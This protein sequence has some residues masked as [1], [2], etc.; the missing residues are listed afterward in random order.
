MASLFCIAE[1]YDYLLSQLEENGGELTEE[2]EEQ[3]A[4]TEEELEDKLRSYKRIIDAQKSNVIYNKDEI[5]RLRERNNS[6]ENANNKLNQAIVS[7]LYKFG[8]RGKSGNYNLKYPDFTV[9]TKASESIEI[10]EHSLDNIVAYL[11]Y[12]INHVLSSEE[13]H[14]VN[15]C[16]KYLDRVA[17]VN[18]TFEVPVSSVEDFSNLIQN[19]YC[20]VPQI[21]I[22][23]DK[24]AIKELDDEASSADV[25]NP[26]SENELM[27]ISDVMDYIGMNRVKKDTAIFK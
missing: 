13:E 7:A 4:I 11:A 26:Y 5:S 2:L 6:F 20:L 21:N 23:F 25:N 22:K 19:D 1:K 15:N 27:K 14:L 24:K 18:L 10:K 16:I 8:T 3:L 17:K 9:Y 12:P